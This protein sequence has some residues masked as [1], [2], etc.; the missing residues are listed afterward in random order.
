MSLWQRIVYISKATFANADRGPAIEPQ[1]G[2]ILMQSRRNNPTRGLVGALY[3]GDGHFFQVLEGEAAAID[4]LLDTL[5]NDPRHDHLTV[6]SRV[7]I[8][9]P[10]FSGWSMKYVA[11]ADEVR[12]LL[13]SFG[14]RRFDPYG[15]DDA[16]VAS[17]VALL[18]HRPSAPD[19]H[20][21]AP[22]RRDRDDAVRLARRALAVSATALLLSLLAIVLA[23]RR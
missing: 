16:Q 23:W 1:I 5:R 15:F 18:Q 12:R 14:H 19:S 17:M 7:G 13:A 2:R 9:R 10:S 3:Y 11:A 4:A 8:E 20:A 22:S 21:E 6:L